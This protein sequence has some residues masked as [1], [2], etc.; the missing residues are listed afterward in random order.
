[1]RSI[2]HVLFFLKRQKQYKV[3][4]VPIYVRITI[5]GQR[6]EFATGRKC[7]PEC[8]DSRS[9]RGI[10]RREEIKTLNHNL[11]H[12]EQMVQ[13]TYFHLLK[14]KQDV[15]A[16]AIKDKF[17]GKAE[18]TVKMLIE[19]FVAHNARVAALVGKE[20]SPATLQRYETTLKHVKEMI[21]KV[22]K[23]QDV[24]V[25]SVN[26]TFINELEFYLRTQ[27]SCANN[28]AVKYVKNFGKIFRICLAS[29]WLTSDPFLNY[30]A[31]LRPVE[32]PF[33]SSEELELISL[34]KFSVRL[35]V[36]RDIFLFSCYTGLAYADVQKLTTQEVALGHD[37]EMWIR[38]TRKKTDTP[39]NVPLLP[40]AL[41]LVDK[42]REHPVSSCL[43]KVF[44]VSSNQKMNAYLKEIAEICGID[45]ELT[46]HIA[47]HTFATT[48]T[49]SNG[50]PIESVS[51]MLGHTNIRTTQ[52]YA[53][54]LD[55]K[56]GHDM[57]LLRKKM[58]IEEHS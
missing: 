46:Y 21:R 4:D 24:P 36:V 6:A 11:I 32:R 39:T 57:G 48:V 54:I 30:K 58:A 53:K 41:E 7:S 5:D 40:A 29:G 47:R 9:G 12:L 13:D 56:V 20:Y 42:Y 3:G 38:T 37:G 33:L 52:H 50:V 17:S 44:P 34:K 15:T 14:E 35:D 16:Q 26:Y 27:R 2:L 25:K 10:G 31:K 19:T 18:K 51:K 23:K 28:T 43:G 22:Y 45:K 8:W 55:M 1:M 49:L